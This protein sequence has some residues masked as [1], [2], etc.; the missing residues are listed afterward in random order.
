MYGRLSQKST[1]VV[2]R[3][4]A[5]ACTNSGAAAAAASFAAGNNFIKSQQSRTATTVAKSS[6]NTELDVA[7][8][9]LLAEPV[10]L[11]STAAQ[12]GLDIHGNLIFVKLVRSPF[13][14]E[15]RIRNS[16]RALRLFK[17]HQ[18]SVLRDTPTTR[19]LVFAC[20]TLVEVKIVPTRTL[21]PEGI[22]DTE[23]VNNWRYE[24]AR[25]R[26]ARELTEK[27]KRMYERVLRKFKHIDDK[28]AYFREGK[29]APDAVNDDPSKQ[30]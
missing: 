7:H 18:V 8:T 10:S 20:R 24:S 30:E 15:E 6:N 11:E 19:G 12:Q 21:F 2:G 26:R 16:T 14:Q 1:R 4:I 23:L 9:T 29:T 22:P 25:D 13:H 27:K 3:H 28:Y 17:I 5:T